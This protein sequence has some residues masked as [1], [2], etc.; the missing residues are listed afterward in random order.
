VV[1]L[2]VWIIGS[3]IFCSG[4]EDQK[5]SYYVWLVATQ[6]DNPKESMR[7]CT[8]LLEIGVGS[9]IALSDPENGSNYFFE[10]TID[11]VMEVTSCLENGAEYI[12]YCSLN[13]HKNFVRLKDI[14][15]E[16]YIEDQPKD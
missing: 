1:M 3:L 13:H 5:K 16:E 12:V 15:W 2:I 7:A 8:T 11:K 4:I 14:G 6:T 9:Q 10:A